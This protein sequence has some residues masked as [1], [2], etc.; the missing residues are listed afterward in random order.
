MARTRT[1]SAVRSRAAVPKGT[2]PRRRRATDRASSAAGG[3]GIFKHILCAID[4]GHLPI[5]AIDLAV[6][7]GQQND[8]TIHLLNVVPGPMGQSATSPIA[9]EPFPSDERSARIR[10]ENIGRKRLA[11]RVAYECIVLSGDP[12]TA[13][14]RAADEFG[15]DLI[16]L[17]T[18]GRTGVKRLLLGSVAEKV[19]RES[20]VPVLTVRPGARA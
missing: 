8:A 5:Q 7:I 13:V 2:A 1:R 17:G 15:A 14:L 4:F 20:P 10:L 11:G 6:R 19:L 3:R 12:A 18:H 16:I 9:L